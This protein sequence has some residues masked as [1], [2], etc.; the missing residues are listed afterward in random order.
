[1]NEQIY[2]ITIGVAQSQ[3]SFENLN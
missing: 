2:S 1:M 3:N